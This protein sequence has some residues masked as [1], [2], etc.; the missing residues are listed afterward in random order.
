LLTSAAH[1]KADNMFDEQYWDHFGPNGETPWQFILASGYSYVYA[2]ENLAKGF[3]TS[4]GVHA[5]WM[6]SASHRENIMNANYKEIGI[7]VVPGTLLG[8][9]VL[10]VV[11]IFGATGSLPE[12]NGETSQSVENETDSIPSTSD[13][14]SEEEADEIDE[15]MFITYP[16]NGDYIDDNTFLMEG[17]S[18]VSDQDIEIFNNDDLLGEALC[19]NGIWDYRPEDTWSDGEYKVHAEGSVAGVSDQIDFVVDTQP[20]I[21]QQ[22]SLDISYEVGILTVRVNVDGQPA[23]VSMI[24]GTKQV[25]MKKNSDGLYEGSLLVTSEDVKGQCE[26]VSSDVSGNYST[27][28]IS[29]MLTDIVEEDDNSFSLG[30]ISDI[31]N[32]SIVI[33]LSVL[34][35]VDVFFLYRL[36]KVESQGKILFKMSLWIIV[37]GISLVIG[38]R[39]TIS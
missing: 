2:G 16:E 28:D 32:R 20:P 33:G 22:E 26:I 6:A 34:L 13:G 5:A 27:L 18:G 35:A 12:T 25:D 31:F 7:A 29:D 23:S 21:F 15:S 10:L 24:V 9:D 39:G 3:T 30:S 36:K 37:L 11:Q 8:E 14:G 17:S 19:E 4:E 1:A 38:T